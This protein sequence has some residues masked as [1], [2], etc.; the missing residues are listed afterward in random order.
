MRSNAP[1]W[2][3]KVRPRNFSLMAEH[4]MCQPG[5]P[6][7]QGLSHDGSPGFAAFHSAKSSGWRLSSPGCTRSPWHRSSRLRL[8][9]FA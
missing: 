6:L 9:S 4:S 1:P 3:S 5:R 7:P 2:M 8:D